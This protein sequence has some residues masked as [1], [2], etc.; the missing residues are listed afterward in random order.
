MTKFRAW[1]K[2]QNKM[3][4]P[5][6]IEFING[7]AYW[8]EASTDGNGGYSN[9]GKVDGIGALFELEQFTDLK[10]VSGKDIYE[11]DIVKS[12]YKYAQPNISQIIMEDGNSYITG[13]DLATGNEMLVSD[14]I[15]EIEIIGNVH[16]NPDLLEESK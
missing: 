11:G 8:A 4:L 6:N 7:Q 14:H 9:D 2:V 3:L 12:N 13:E 15:G 5:D 10:D 1:D 16:E